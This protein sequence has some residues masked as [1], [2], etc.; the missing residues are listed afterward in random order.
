M[1]PDLLEIGDGGTVADEASLGAG[2]VEGGWMTVAPT[3]V[4][5]RAFVGN[6]AVVPAGADLGDGSLVGV[7]SLAPLGPEGG[8]RPGAGWLGSPPRL[9]PRREAS[10][11][12]TEGRTYCPPR[13]SC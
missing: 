8:A 11:C 4:G 9:L 6:S 10:A 13:G 5:S 2:R 3:R 1:M 12:F 7:L